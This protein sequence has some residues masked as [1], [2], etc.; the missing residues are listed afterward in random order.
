MRLP[1]SFGGVELCAP[2]A[3]S[4]RV[5]LSRT[6]DDAISLLVADE[7]GGLIASVDSLV[8]REISAAQLGAAHR[9]T[10]IRCSG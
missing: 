3:F 8:M 5:C 6:A 7:A 2:G 9:A 1:F 4:L 10:A